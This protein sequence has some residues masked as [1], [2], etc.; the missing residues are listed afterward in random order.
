V[1]WP[2]I[3]VL[4]SA[5]I[6]KPNNVERTGYVDEIFNF[7]GIITLRVYPGAKNPTHQISLSD[8]VRMRLADRPKSVKEVPLTPSSVHL[9][10]GGGKFGD[11]EPGI[12]HIEQRT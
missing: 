10:V 5:W 12:C 4:K 3:G 6:I 2:G 8:G 9:T 7:G 11:W 1:T